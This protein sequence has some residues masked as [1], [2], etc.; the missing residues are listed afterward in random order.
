MEFFVDIKSFQSQKCPGVDSASNRNEY[1]EHFLGGKGGRCVKL[2]TLPPYSAVVMKSEN[3]NFLEPSG[4]LRA[5]NGTDLPVPFMVNTFFY[6]R[7]R[8]AL[9]VNFGTFVLITSNNKTHVNDYKT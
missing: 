5:S 3:L 4:P 9:Y 8:Q 2:T 1:Q 6:E 7:C